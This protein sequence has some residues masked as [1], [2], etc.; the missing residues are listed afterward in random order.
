MSYVG[1]FT[2]KGLIRRG[3]EELF[4]GDKYLYRNDWH[5]GWLLCEGM[6]YRRGLFRQEKGEF[7]SRADYICA[8][9]FPQGAD[10]LQL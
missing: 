1:R 5:K 8:V 3:K 10:S 2:T 6:I 7:Y 4:T 9:G